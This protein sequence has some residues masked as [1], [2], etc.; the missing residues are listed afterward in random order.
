MSEQIK[1]GNSIV[2]P[3]VGVLRC[4]DRIYYVYPVASYAA[5]YDASEIDLLIQV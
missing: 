1:C 2:V 3:T 5:A 4:S